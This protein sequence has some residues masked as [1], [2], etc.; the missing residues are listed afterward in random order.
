M[1]SHFLTLRALRVIDHNTSPPVFSH[2]TTHLHNTRLAYNSSI[3]LKLG[4][5]K[6]PHRE[7][8][9]HH[10]SLSR[11]WIRTNW[12]DLILFLVLRVTLI[13]ASI[14]EDALSILRSPDHKQEDTIKAEIEDIKPAHH[15]SIKVEFP[16]V[17]A[18]VDDTQH[19]IASGSGSRMSFALNIHFIA[20]SRRIL[21][22][23]PQDT[24]PRK[25]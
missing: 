16:E 8:Y 20:C 2:L 9:P 10:P 18:E 11:S 17:K 24:N 22:K 4:T 25:P 13:S 6:L 12:V 1:V 3:D 5:K 19:N 21:S 15:I 23:H 7:N 14:D